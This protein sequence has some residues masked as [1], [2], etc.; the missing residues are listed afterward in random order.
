MDIGPLH[1]RRGETVTI[2][3]DDGHHIFLLYDIEGILTC[4]DERTEDDRYINT[5]KQVVALEANG[6]RVLAEGEEP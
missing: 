3:T 4:S 2:T 1:L 6:W 5:A